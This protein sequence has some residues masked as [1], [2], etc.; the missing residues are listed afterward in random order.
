[1]LA[2]I[3]SHGP[4]ATKAELVEALRREEVN[5]GLTF[6]YCLI[7]AGTSLNRAPSD[8][9]WGA[10]DILSLDSGGNY[11]GYIGDLCRMAI[12]GEPDSELEDLLAEVDEIQL[13][14]RKPIRAGAQ[15]GEIYASAGEVLQTVIARAIRSSLSRTGWA[16]SATRRR[17][18]PSHGPIPYPAYDADR[19]LEFGMVI[20]IETTI[21][22]P[23][24]GFIKL[25]DTV[26]V[27]D[28][29][30]EAFGDRGRGWNRGGARVP[31]R[32]GC[33]ADNLPHPVPSPSEKGIVGND[34]RRRTRRPR[35][36]DH[37]SVADPGRCGSAPGHI[38]RRSHIL[39]W[40]PAH[41]RR[42]SVNPE[43]RRSSNP[44][45]ENRLHDK[46]CQC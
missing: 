25:E 41:R 5:R 39:V 11:K 33:Q 31:N 45:P 35:A 40:R 32:R 3:A 1:M 15:G 20:S 29:G 2:V 10:G 43:A 6:E 14:A 30:W 37:A 23:R 36:K 24:R 44:C 17:A 46:L 34:G 21:A 26:A 27:T 18:S 42:I 13:A 12:Q 38:R 16:S 22:H 8:Q 4:G 28:Q 9:V 19:P 7:T